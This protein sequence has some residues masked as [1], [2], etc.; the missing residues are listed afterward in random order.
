LFLKG[1]IMPH[2][3]LTLSETVLIELDQSADEGR[4]VKPFAD[5]IGRAHV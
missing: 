5:E 3:W 4:V 2:T 1:G